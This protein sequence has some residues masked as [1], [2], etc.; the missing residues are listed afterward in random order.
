[1]P[2]QEGESR[3]GLGEATKQVAEH[4]SAIARLE[5][6]L[7][8]LELGRKVKSLAVAIALALA[9]AILLLFALGFG[10]ASAA[11]ALAIPLSTWLGLLIVAGGL[12]VVIGLLGMLAVRMFKQGTPPVPKQAIEEAKLT[13]EAIKSD[14]RR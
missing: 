13:G 9:A 7:A 4:A 3:T 6:E 14:G 8:A 5:L 10:L 11:A 1:M 2:I 12:I